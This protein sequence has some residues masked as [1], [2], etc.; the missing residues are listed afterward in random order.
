MK[1]HAR[2]RKIKVGAYYRNNANKTR[3]GENSPY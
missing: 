1:N 2:K 3:R